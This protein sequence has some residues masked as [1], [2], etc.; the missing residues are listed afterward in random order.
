M[1]VI[2]E[3]NSVTILDCHGDI[4]MVG[5]Y[6][7]E[8]RLFYVDLLELIL[9]SRSWE[10]RLIASAYRTSLKEHEEF[11]VYHAALPRATPEI[12]RLYR[13]V[14]PQIGHMS[15]VKLMDAIKMDAIDGV[16]AELSPAMIQQITRIEQCPSCAIFRRRHEN[17]KKGSGIYPAAAG[18]Y[19][20][21]DEWGPY[22]PDSMGKFILIPLC[23]RRQDFF[24]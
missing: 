10:K 8:K 24:Y 15:P 19:F 12:I 1:E 18:A 23:V 14:H 16:P 17:I 11:F 9:I 7:P 13:R 2:Y 3:F 6:D 5:P 20:T 21:V 4:L 22:P